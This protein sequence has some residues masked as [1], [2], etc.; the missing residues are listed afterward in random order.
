MGTMSPPR[1]RSRSRRLGCVALFLMPF[2]VGALAMSGCVAHSAR[3]LSQS[4]AHQVRA[5]LSGPDGPVV[6]EGELVGP[7]GGQRLE[8]DP[9][10]GPAVHAFDLS[11]REGKTRRTF[12]RDFLANG[13]SLRL[14]GGEQ[15]AL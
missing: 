7:P 2:L 1:L 9:G 8:G 11:R 14:A 5:S 13:V 6:L 15:V 12:C 10:P 3:L 4:R